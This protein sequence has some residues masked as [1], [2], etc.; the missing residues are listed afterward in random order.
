MVTPGRDFKGAKPTPED[1]ARATVTAMLRVVPPAVPGIMFLSGG[2]SEEEAT[3][4]LNAMNQM[5][6][7]K[8]WALSFSFGRALQAS[9][10]A[11]WRGEDKNTKE[12]QASALLLQRAQANSM[13]V[14]GK[15][16]NDVNT[17]RGAP[18]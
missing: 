16:S 13:A 4:N 11:K 3:L 7:R 2:Q 1:I 17:D 8:P 10:M 15:Y 14:L 5:E 18:E 6:G 12:A 9:C